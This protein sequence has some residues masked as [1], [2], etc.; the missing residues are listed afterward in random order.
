M[1]LL[2]RVGAPGGS[3][4]IWSRAIAVS[5]TSIT[6]EPAPACAHKCA[7]GFKQRHER[8]QPMRT[9]AA[10]RTGKLGQAVPLLVLVLALLLASRGQAQDG[11][12]NCAAGTYNVD[13]SC[14]ACDPGQ[15]DSDSDP[16]TPCED[17]A[18]GFY[19]PPGSAKC[20]FVRLSAISIDRDGELE[21]NVPGDTDEAEFA[22]FDGEACGSPGHDNEAE[23]GPG[24]E[25]RDGERVVYQQGRTDYTN[26]VWTSSCEGGGTVTITD[27]RSESGWDFL[28]L[29]SDADSVTNS[30]GPASENGG[31]DNSGD[32]GRL[33][34]QEEPGTVSGVAAVQYISDWDFQEPGAGF[35]MTHVC[36]ELTPTCYDLRCA[37]GIPV[38]FC[39]E[40]PYCGSPDELHEVTCCADSSRSGFQQSYQATCDDVW[41]SRNV[42][43]CEHGLNY[44]DA[45]A[46]CENKG[47]R[48][49]TADELARDC[50]RDGGCGH[51]RDLVWTSDHP[52][53]VTVTFES[54]RGT[55][56]S[57]TCAELDEVYGGA[58]SEPAVYGSDMVCGE[59]DNGLSNDEH[60]ESSNQ[61]SGGGG[62]AHDGYDHAVAICAAIGARLCTAKELTADETRGSGCGHDAEMIWSSTPCDGGG[63]LTAIGS[64]E[65]APARVSDGSCTNLR[66]CTNC[67]A[68][69]ET[70]PGVRCCADVLGSLCPASWTIQVREDGPYHAG[71]EIT[72][73]FNFDASPGVLYSSAG[74]EHFDQVVVSRSSATSATMTIPSEGTVC[75]G[76][77]IPRECGP[78]RN[79]DL[80][81]PV[82][83]N[84]IP[85]WH[86]HNADLLVAD[87]DGRTDVL[88]VADFGNFSSVYQT[89]QT[90]PG[91]R[92]F[93][94]F[95]VW[96]EP[97]NN[98]AD[99]AYC[100]ST[101]SNGLVDIHEG[102]AETVSRHGE[103]RVC[104]IENQPGT[105]QTADGIYEA[106]S[107][108]TTLALHSEGE[109]T[110]YFDSI[111][112]RIVEDEAPF[113]YLG[114]FIDSE[115]RDIVDD[116][117]TVVHSAVAANV[118]EAEEECALACASYRY[119]GL[120]WTNACF[121]G[122]RYGTLGQHTADS[123]DA[124]W[125][126]CDVDSDSN[127]YC[128]NGE[129]NCGWRNA[130]YELATAQL[131]ACPQIHLLCVYAPPSLV[132][133]Q[134]VISF[135]RLSLQTDQFSTNSKR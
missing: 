15:A 26:C 91:Q 25:L 36:P 116:D 121:C 93:V 47:G 107:N 81:G 103:F 39:E 49:C 69:S 101:D 33:S 123:C 31:V 8:G 42:E 58:W 13:E 72:L 111:T 11:G 5:D 14:V 10:G 70:S 27:F 102:T 4:R 50:S 99:N 44:D 92:Y 35:T 45:F 71:E 48:L 28:N 34:G 80:S 110:A 131:G 38:D 68:T 90:V 124:G 112:V 73:G 119:F 88:H 54:S 12:T 133:V 74:G 134:F 122:N 97:L 65:E 2:P 120:Q 21:L 132:I 56:S 100:S 135:V 86:T 60:G 64:S 108:T 66:R 6:H 98:V 104:P 23:P 61:C 82:T 85:G 43:D 130:V 41:G 46:Y 32:L 51:N 77:C 75:F 62:A 76:A 106:V 125:C 89:V 16:A 52:P 96:A 57:L 78:L 117:G 1:E 55:C 105:W 63:R 67:T 118:A 115:D 19:S 95:D 53:V 37:R 79:C 114:C 40:E 83:D 29:F 129:E 7:E 24:H 20:P 126:Q 30:I 87:H 3:K 84:T 127:T 128:A 22:E 9:T 59:S 18:A 17:C 109:W 94:Q 113:T